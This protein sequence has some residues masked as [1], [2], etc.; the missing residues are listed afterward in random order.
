[1]FDVSTDGLEELLKLADGLDFSGLSRDL[2]EQSEHDARARLDTLI[3][4]TPQRGNYERTGALRDSVYSSAETDSDGFT[5]TLGAVGGSKGRRYAAPNETG[6][7]ASYNSLDSLLEAARGSNDPLNLP[8][9][10]RGQGGLEARP[11]ISPAL[12][13]MERQ[14]EGKLLGAIDKAVR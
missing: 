2:A 14:L 11:Y 8:A 3:Y 9:Y 12:A 7:L 4:N 5:V 13:E 10:P 6:S 1:M